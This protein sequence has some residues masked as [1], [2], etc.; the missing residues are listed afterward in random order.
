MYHKDR[1][2]VV[3]KNEIRKQ[4]NQKVHFLSNFLPSSPLASSPL[5]SSPHR[6]ITSS[7]HRLIALIASSP[8][9]LITS[10]QLIL[11]LSY[12]PYTLI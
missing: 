6:L 5:A 11:A 8:Y 7:P 12:G 2:K 9:N 4:I 10:K 3:K 1:A